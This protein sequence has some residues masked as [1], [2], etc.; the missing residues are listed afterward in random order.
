MYNLMNE[1]CAEGKAVILITSDLPELISMS[2]RIYVMHQGVFTAEL[3]A[4]E[5]DQETIMHYASG[6]MKRGITG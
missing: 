5:A 2:D 4:D 6:I 1:L 3:A